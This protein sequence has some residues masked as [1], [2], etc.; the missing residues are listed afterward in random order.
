MP[1]K[2]DKEFKINTVR[3]VVEEKLKPSKVAQDLGL[4]L[5]T[6]ERWVREFHQEGMHAFPGKGHLKPDDQRLH[7]LERDN[8]VLRRERDILKKALA[9]FSRS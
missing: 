2:F 4:G 9:I 5:S 6:L 8:E 7:Q 3:L 1:R